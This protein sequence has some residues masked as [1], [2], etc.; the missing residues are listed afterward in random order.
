[1]NTYI[2]ILLFNRNKCIS[3][4]AQGSILLV[5]LLVLM[6]L[7]ALIAV[8][9]T[10]ILSRQKSY[11][12]YLNKKK[13]LYLAESANAMARSSLR[14][15]EEI[16]HWQNLEAVSL[17]DG[18][19]IAKIISL[20]NHLWQIDTAARDNSKTFIASIS[21]IVRPEFDYIL[22]SSGKIS[23]QG[24]G[25]MFITGNVYGQEFVLQ[26]QLIY[27][28]VSGSLI[29]P[30]TGITPLPDKIIPFPVID[31]AY[32]K[33]L[34]LPQAM[35]VQFH[36]KNLML[37]GKNAKPLIIKG[38]YIVTKNIVLENVEVHG[39]LISLEG[40]ISVGNGC[41]IYSENNFPALAS[42]KGTITLESRNNPITIAGLL[43][44]QKIIL[45]GSIDIIGAIYSREQIV[46]QNS[47]PDPLIIT[48]RFNE[49]VLQTKS[50][51]FKW[52]QLKNL[53]WKAK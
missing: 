45:N 22:F 35:S 47:S 48:L 1:M 5:V 44:A 40:N 52:N 9:I 23:G 50:L 6:I 11:L 14:A 46:F 4:R 25:K 51:H 7:V 38:I 2:M 29:M 53:S 34:S 18:I 15:E 30:S 10:G 21:N 33:N 43:Y 31:S 42:L 17:R 20:D 13:T 24:K 27:T 19:I 8:V 28:Q 41:S 36:D 32:Y 12:T 3:H 26:N 39:A 49:T 37:T 16:V